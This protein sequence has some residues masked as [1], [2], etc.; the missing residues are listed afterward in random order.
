MVIPA[1][2]LALSA[3]LSFAVAGVF[4]KRGLEH[5]TPLA[6]VQV[7][8][9]FNAAALWALAAATAPL[10]LLLTPGVWPF[11]LAGLIA[12][13]LARLALF[14]GV[15][16]VGVS[17]SSALTS[18]APLFA[19]LM[20]VAFLGERPAP[21]ALVGVAAIVVG[22][23]L[24]SARGAGDR[25]WRRR[26]LVFPLLAALGFALRDN[27]S[28]WGFR[29]F[30][31]PLLASTAATTTSLLVMWGYAWLQRG[32]GR[33][34]MNGTGL[35]LLA[36]AGLSEAAAYLTMWR[37]LQLGAVSVVSPL[38]NS[39]ALFAVVLAA[40]FLRDLEQVTWRVVAATL[41]IVGG[42][43]VVIRFAA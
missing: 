27:I 21:P 28:R 12:P 15:H 8:V 10:G 41:L 14:T 13:G 33:L 32:T 4:L 35:V 30:A 11:L 2:L 18:C 16:R 6:A 26:D 38:V 36:L 3:A 37:A 34:R 22:G 40:L 19:V 1:P 24:I 17:R 43:A 20:A 31:D 39:H 42:V 23:A 5:A 25:R 29:G 7:S 9:L